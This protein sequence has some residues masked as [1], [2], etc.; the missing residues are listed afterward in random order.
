MFGRMVV[1]TSLAFLE[2]SQISKNLN[3]QG[4][5]VEVIN[6]QAVPAN[7]DSGLDQSD[8]AVAYHLDK[9]VDVTE[10]LKKPLATTSK[11][12]TKQKTNEFISPTKQV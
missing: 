11:I 4:A 3:T 5:T 10:E 7:P 1:F 2:N 12:D 8:N 6:A 9:A